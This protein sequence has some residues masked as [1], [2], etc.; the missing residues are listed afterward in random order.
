[1]KRAYL[2][3]DEVHH[4]EHRGAK[5]SVNDT[6]PPELHVGERSGGIRWSGFTSYPY[7][8]GAGVGGGEYPKPVIYGGLHSFRPP[9]TRL[10]KLV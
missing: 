10:C 8:L 4:A 6:T 2:A 1:M 7:P 5:V 9:A 3:G